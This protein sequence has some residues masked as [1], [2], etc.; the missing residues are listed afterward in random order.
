MDTEVNPDIPAPQHK[1]IVIQ[2]PDGMMEIAGY[3]DSQPDAF[4]S[5]A[6]NEGVALCLV[7]AKPRYYLYRPLVLPEM[8]GPHGPS[9]G[10][11]DPRQQ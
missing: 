9:G 11:F 7:V 3:V 8:V 1:R 5:A 2:H 10:S 4:I 6:M